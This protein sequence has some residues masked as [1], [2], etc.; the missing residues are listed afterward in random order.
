MKTLKRLLKYIK[1]FKLSLILATVF[2]FLG[3]FLSL[4]VP[5][6]IGKSVDN[7][8][9]IN[10]VNFS[11]LFKVLI[12]L[13]TVIVLSAFFQWLMSLL[14]NSLSYKT[15]EKLR[16]D[17]FSKL[18]KVSLKSIDE[19]PHGDI[20]ST[21]IND[22]EIVSTGLLQGFTQTFTSIMT[23][24]GTIALMFSI[25][26]YLALSVIIL[27]PLSLFMSS[28]IAKKTHKKYTQQAKLRG[29][30]TSLSSEMID[31]AFVVSAFN[32]GNDELERFKIINNDLEKVGIK[33]HFYSALSNPCTRFVNSIVYAVV[34]I[35]G[36]IFAVSG[37]ITVGAIASAL[38]YCSQYTKPINEISS[39]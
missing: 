23:I 26:Q 18:T 3:V 28:F 27:T 20:I 39:F 35:L 12:T 2:A 16:S 29:N 11:M 6:L 15:V 17:T 34:G 33:A 10:D 21:V 32:K 19:I 13:S 30:L 4:L 36:S 25:N 8:I 37:I 31:G 1:Q 24:I 22:I 5:I 7:I 38:A 9:G 14:I